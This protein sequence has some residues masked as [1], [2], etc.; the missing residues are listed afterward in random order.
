MRYDDQGSRESLQRGFERLAGAH[1]QVVG[2]FVQEQGIITLADQAHKGKS[3][4]LPAG[5]QADA[6]V[7]HVGAETEG[8]REGAQLADRRARPDRG[9][10]LQNGVRVGHVQQL[11]IVEADVRV[12]PPGDD[13]AIGQ[14]APRQDPQQGGL[15]ASVGADDADPFP[16]ADTQGKITDQGLAVVAF[17]HAARL[18]G[19][20]ATCPPRFQADA[21]S[22]RFGGRPP[23]RLLPLQLF[24]PG[25]GLLGLL[26]GQ[27]SP[28]EILRPGDLLRLPPPGRL[29]LPPGLARGPDIVGIVPGIGPHAPPVQM[30]GPRACLVQEE[31]VVRH[32]DHARAQAHETGFEPFAR[33]QIQMVRRLV[34][35]QQIAVA[36]QDRREGRPPP[37]PA[38]QLPGQLVPGFRSQ[39]QAGQGGFQPGA[40]GVSVQPAEFLL[41][42]S[43]ALAE[44][45]RVARAGLDRRAG[46][47]QRLFEFQDLGKGVF[48]G[49][50]EQVP[51]GVLVDGRFLAQIVQPDAA[52]HLDRSAA[53]FDLSG[54]QRQK[55]RLSGPVLPDQ[56]VPDAALQVQGRP[57]EQ[58]LASVVENDV[59]QREDGHGLRAPRSGSIGIRVKEPLHHG[60]G[61]RSEALIRSRRPVQALGF[62]R[63][64][65]GGIPQRSLKVREKWA[66]LL[67][68]HC[69]DTS[70]TDRSKRL[71]SFLAES[72]RT[73]I[74]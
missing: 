34:Q 61:S 31:P 9:E 38:R 66:R 35:K 59:L 21:R 1:V 49:P 52:R 57:V 13:A 14:Q 27:V 15:A 65:R 18:E 37:L 45:F 46:R 29:L 56:G 53:G 2:R 5:Q 24:P 69:F 60:R 7:D 26:A 36:Q 40:P 73:C 70:S 6:P 64:L 42:L 50:G 22:G 47:V 20:R 44:R 71:N 11:L 67:K 23:D 62:L 33:A 32:D 54:Q 39:A 74:R 3:P 51:R 58:G 72:M 16:A 30:Q 55:G 25:L 68:P 63:Y 8:A 43:E 12:V 19:R 41:E 17:R 4:A 10:L 48:G 28:D